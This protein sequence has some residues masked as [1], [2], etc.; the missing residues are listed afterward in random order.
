VTHVTLPRNLVDEA[1]RGGNE[2]M[3]AWIATLPDL[4]ATLQERWSLQ[5]DAPFQPGGVAAWVAPARDEAGRHVVLKIGWPHFE[6]EHEGDGLREWHGKGTA[7]LYG[8]DVVDGTI[9]LLIER[10]LPGTTL[11]AV[12]DTEQDVVVAELLQRLWCDPQPG[13]PFRT[14]QFMCDVWADGYERKAAAGSAELDPGLARA[15][16][17][18]FRTLPSSAERNVLLATDL[19]AGNVLQAEREPWLV[20]DPKPFVGDP[21][22][23]ALQHMLNCDA[24]LRADPL[25]LVRRMAG[26]LDLDADR[27]RLWLFAR[28]VEESP[29]WPGLAPIAR[30]VAPS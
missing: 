6:S 15:G 3:H 9:A 28:C 13:H 8:T 25:A 27:L 1:A 29:R 18:L 22:Y 14:L 11:T 20:I 26:L 10:C 12:A 23:D 7:L 30:R 2:A 21:T 16:I 19:H 17:E 24:R 4:V 5:L